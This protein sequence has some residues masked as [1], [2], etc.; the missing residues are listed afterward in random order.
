MSFDLLNFYEEIKKDGIMFCYSGPISQS[1]VE[2]I[3]ETLRINMKLEDAGI[4]T[5]NTVF[6]IFVEQMHNI[7][8]YSA[9]KIGQD[10]ESRQQLSLGVLVIGREEKGFYVF[11]GNRLLNE[12]V[13]KLRERIESIRFL[14]K[15]ELKA[16][17]KQ[18]RRESSDS[19]NA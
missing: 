2:G 10:S 1:T 8:N 15:D 5:A 18:K 17:Y 4:T 6:S 11:C 7:L 13:P 16:I 19:E 3:G 9:E 14:D 12:D